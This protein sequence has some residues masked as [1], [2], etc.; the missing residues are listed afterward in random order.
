MT[1]TRKF[2]WLWASFFLFVG[3]VGLVSYD[4]SQANGDFAKSSTGKLFKDLG[5][6]EQSQQA[7]R[8]TLSSSARGYLWL[9]TNTPVYYSNTVE[10][11][12]PYGQLSLDIATISLKKICALYGNMKEYVVEKTPVVLETIEQYAPGVLDTVQSYVASGYNFV[13][14]YSNEYYQITVNYLST[15]VFVGE[16]APE[17][18]QNKTQVALNAT[19]F[20]MSTY[21]H[22]FREQVHVYSKLP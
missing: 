22:W 12:K 3:I 2:P 18:I 11:L 16:W 20:H 1:S 15:K 9:E 6:L 14:K 4:V 21:F 5:I 19:K 10:T 13:K 17:I 8:K 7:W